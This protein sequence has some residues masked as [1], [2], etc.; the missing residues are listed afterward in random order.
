MK[1]SLPHCFR[2]PWLLKLGGLLLVGYAVVAAA[3]VHQLRSHLRVADHLWSVVDVPAPLN[4]TPQGEMIG[5]GVALRVDEA[6]KM[7]KIVKVFPGSPATKAGLA[8]GDLIREINGAATAGLKLE[9]CVQM[10]RGPEGTS[11]R[12]EIIPVKE[13]TSI[14][15]EL[16]RLPFRLPN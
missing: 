7:P 11:V 12:L 4:Q 13:G 3:E 2:R 10:I 1:I 14:E 6:T 9:Q 8:E 15:V 5:I 16:T